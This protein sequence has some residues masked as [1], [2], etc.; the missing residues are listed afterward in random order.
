MRTFISGLAGRRPARI[1]LPPNLRRG[2]RP[3]AGDLLA[4]PC[5]LYAHTFLM[6]AIR[7]HRFFLPN[8]RSNIEHVLARAGCL[9]ADDR[10]GGEELP[11]TQEFLS[12]M[13]GWSRAGAGVTTC[14]AGIGTAKA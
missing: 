7:T 9:M 10:V 6:Q 13:A 5:A 12:I 1:F 2:H 4:R 14:G 8:G 3:K 11:L